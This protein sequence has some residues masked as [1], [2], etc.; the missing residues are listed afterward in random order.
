MPLCVNVFFGVVA[1]Y[2]MNGMDKQQFTSIS[3]KDPCLN[4]AQKNVGA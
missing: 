4:D 3:R 2:F 1:C